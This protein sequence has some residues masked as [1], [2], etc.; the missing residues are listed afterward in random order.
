M[1]ALY[2]QHCHRQPVWLFSDAELES[3]S[4]QPEELLLAMLAI[5]TRFSESAHFR[6]KNR[7]DMSQRF[8]DA[9]RNLVML[10]IA[11]AGVGLG[12]IQSLCLLA[13]AGFAG[14]NN[15]LTPTPWGKTA[16]DTFLAPLHLNLARDLLRSAGL[17]LRSHALTP[18]DQPTKRLFWSIYL[19][20]QLYG[21]Q[22]SR[23]ISLRD[24]LD[25]IRYCVTVGE[26]ARRA[27]TLEPPQIPDDASVDGDSLDHGIWSSTLCLSTL[28]NE[29]R[30]YIQLCASDFE[31][32]PWAPESYYTLIGSYMH[33]LE[34][35]LPQPHR[36]NGKQFSQCPPAVLEQERSYW[37]PWVFLQ[38]SYH[39]IYTVINH[40]FLLTSRLQ[41][42]RLKIPNTFWGRSAEA[43]LV[44]STWVCRLITMVQG[45]GF[46]LSD[47]FLGYIV[48]VAATA[49]LF[50]SCSQ[51]EEL[52]RNA[53][54][55]FDKCMAFLDG[56]AA[57]W[58]WCRGIKQNLELLASQA[59]DGGTTSRVISIDTTLMLDIFDYSRCREADHPAMSAS[60]GDGPGHRLF[61]GS[62]SLRGDRIG[63]QL[64]TMEMSEDPSDA[65]AG[66]P[67]APP[68]WRP[69]SASS[70]GGR[71]GDGRSGGSD[72]EM[73]PDSGATPTHNPIRQS[74]AEV[75]HADLELFA[76]PAEA[77]SDGLLQ[78]IFGSESD[79]WN[80]DA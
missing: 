67:V 42:L 9:A 7:N 70:G 58:Q 53:R 24:G 35:Q 56:Q 65:A 43:A 66:R 33:E 59:F 16:R 28:W 39:G 4:E 10:K 60:T 17:D 73:I 45:K 18:A 1:V 20:E 76:L 37:A 22:G 62:L 14:G 11:N 49:Q 75:V 78:N 47:P 68:V 19:L 63:S 41:S 27:L 80:V 52:S 79:W 23:V 48:G 32:A 5:T 34:T 44:H 12:T 6:D 64:A 31:R 38:L 74:A 57:V 61:D 54:E 50:Y 40:P 25:N 26:H 72:V 69:A 15:M 3:L 55:S 29:V 2:R 8:G 30:N 13:W 77:F 21:T 36:S 51:N 71:G 46:D